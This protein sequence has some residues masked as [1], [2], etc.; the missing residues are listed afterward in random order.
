MRILYFLKSSIIK[1]KQISVGIGISLIFLCF[2]LSTINHYGFSWD[3][4]YHHYAGRFHLG[5][6]VPSINDVP[7]VPFTPP[8]PRLT[9]E[10]PFGPF[11]D[12]IPTL[13]HHILYE[14]LH[15]LAEDSAYNFP[16]IL[17]GVL[18]I[19]ILYF[20]LL[21][22]VGFP[23]AVIGS[24]SLALLPVY[25]GYA[26]NN[27]K[28]I[29]NAMAFTFSLYAFYR[30][31]KHKRFKDLVIASLIFAFAFNI[32]INSVVIP[33]ICFAWFVIYCS[34]KLIPGFHFNI[35]KILKQVQHGRF[36]IVLFYFLLAPLFAV[37]LWWPFWKHPIQK[38]LELPHFYSNNT[39]NMP[40]LFY[41][42][43][44]H[45]GF[46]IPFSYP[47][48]YL[49][50]TIPIPL[51]FFSLLG[52]GFCIV[53][54]KKNYGIYSLILLW[55]CIPLARYASPKSGAIDG[56]RHFLEIVYPLCALGAIGFTRLFINKKRI[57]AVL[58]SIFLLHLI[59]IN[60]HFHPYETSYFNSFI[61]GIKGAVGKFDIDFWG[62]PQKEAILY[63]NT[64][65]P[66]HAYVH[67]VM[68]QS[69]AAMYLRDDLRKNANAKD[70]WNSDFVVLLNR[71]SFFT[72]Y[73]V[74][75]YMS[76]KKVQ[77]K[78]I[79]SRSIDAVPLVWI[80]KK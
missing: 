59:F 69:S 79:F 65:A 66:P 19:S 8:D 4:H 74:T 45:S 2:Y 28:D 44:L 39:I 75:G 80:F 9:L 21:E 60:I 10:D 42:T 33:I 36:I 25:V 76:E 12:I 16:I 77:N 29:P 55:L 43:I 40:V 27:M 30:L 6:V 5:L 73:N 47:F 51:L 17:S 37:L 78:V 46:N 64:I 31:V 63:L 11:T 62:T 56:V 71:E 20:F 70:I 35:K 32:K 68:A 34:P 49:L 13:F 15:V 18:G 72:V 53:N 1:K 67:I 48:S 50:I 52:I 61:G 23:E 3:F 22:S 57:S 54:W 7:P 38:L 41:G 24:I 26:H 58:L 14:N